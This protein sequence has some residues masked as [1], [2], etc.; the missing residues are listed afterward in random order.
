ML[1]QLAVSMLHKIVE[2]GQTGDKCN[3]LFKYLVMYVTNINSI[4]FHK[5]THAFRYEYSSTIG[6][7]TIGIG[8]LGTICG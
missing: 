6:I 8:L 5:T 2:R 4:I 7:L 3:I 1:P